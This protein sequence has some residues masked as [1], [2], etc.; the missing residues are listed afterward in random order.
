MWLRDKI[1]Q[2]KDDI[3]GIIARQP[4]PFDTVSL[5]SHQLHESR[6]SEYIEDSFNIAEGHIIKSGEGVACEKPALSPIATQWVC[7]PVNAYLL[8]NAFTHLES[9]V[10]YLGNINKYFLE[11]GWGWAKYRSLKL[12][13]FRKRKAVI[14]KSKNPVYVFS[15]SGYHGV[16][17]DLSAIL[18]LLDRGFKFDIVIDPDD[19]WMNA[20]LD[21]FLPPGVA[22]IWAPKGAWIKASLTFSVTKS[23]FGEFVNKNMIERLSSAAVGFREHRS[24]NDIFIS[25]EDSSRRASAFESEVA[26]TYKN[27][28]YKKILLSEL[29][30]QDQVSLFASARKVAGIHGAGFVNLV[31]SAPGVRV[32]EHFH[33]FHFNSCYSAIS[34]YL[35]HRYRC[36]VLSD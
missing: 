9:G 26:D 1:S 4:H 10:V 15:S 25:R 27:S 7:N 31:W 19:R 2:A 20:L 30:V 21:L 17:E 23:G 8:R 36:H 13:R 6:F 33:A 29:P 34:R 32:D 24:S 11:T 28:G 35:Q 5:L 18:T 3:E 14:I 16:V 12:K 22:R